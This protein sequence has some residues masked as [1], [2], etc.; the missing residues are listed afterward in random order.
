[1]E[2]NDIL[3]RYELA[4]ERCKTD[5]NSDEKIF[6]GFLCEYYLR[7]LEYER[8]D[9]VEIDLKMNCFKT[10]FDYARYI[11]YSDDDFIRVVRQ[12]LEIYYEQH[13]D[14]VEFDIKNTGVSALR[15]KSGANYEQS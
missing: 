2:K 9:C 15:K 7:E 5:K 1:M 13:K 3:E 4:I 12:C 11:I 8:S 14:V 10:T 6:A